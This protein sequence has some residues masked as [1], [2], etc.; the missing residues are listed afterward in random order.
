MERK[1]KGKKNWRERK[2]HRKGEM[3]VKNKKG[4]EKKERNED[5]I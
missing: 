2:K 4:R 5:R 1:K 3:E